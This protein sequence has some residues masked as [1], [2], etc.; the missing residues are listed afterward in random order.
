M[1]IRGFN[2]IVTGASSGIGTA[3]AKAL[4]EKGANL[5][6]IARRKERID[7]LASEIQEKNKV[8]IHTA[9][10]DVRDRSAVQSWV[11]ALPNEFKAPDILVNN[12]GLA[13]GFSKIQDG[14]FQDWDEMIDTNIK[15][16]LN[17]SRTLLP[18][19]V[20]RKK[21]H[22]IHIGSIA[23]HEAYP[24]GNVYCAT[25]HAVAAINRSMGIDT[26]GTGV[27]SSSVD[28]GFVIT[29]FAEVRFHGDSD[30]A[31]A[32]Y[33]GMKPLSADDVADA[34][35][36]CATRPEHANVREMIL[37]PSAQATVTQI[38]RDL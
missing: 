31:N 1:D 24:S 3:C 5:A 14:S 11:D 2:A 25:K 13:R 37:M 18:N 26:L 34:V 36:F 21:G 9:Q 20:E 10:L 32:V 30:K 23:G 12:A 33:K 6:L 7:A 19:M 35:V 29:E 16:L 28:P 22:V 17:I 38:H 8:N 27:R 15:G 4:A